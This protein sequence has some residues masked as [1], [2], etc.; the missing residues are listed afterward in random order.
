MR[1]GVTKRAGAVACRF[2]GA[3]ETERDPAAERLVCRELAPPFHRA[4]RL[5]RFSASPRQRFAR[6]DISVIEARAL[7]VEPALEFACVTQVKSVQ[8]WTAIQCDSALE[9]SLIQQLLELN[10]VA[11][12]VIDV[13]SQVVASGADSVLAQSR[14]QDVQRVGQLAAGA[15][16][17]TLRPQQRNDLVAAHALAV[18]SGQN[19]EERQAMALRGT[20]PYRCASQA[21]SRVTQLL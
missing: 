20:T 1:T 21:E 11:G 9:V 3:H 19:G 2:Q 16:A 6:A 17:W 8:Q 10:D 5:A 18:R 13:Q 14:A 15:V 7:G 12:D 4:R